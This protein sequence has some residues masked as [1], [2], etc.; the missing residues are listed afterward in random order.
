MLRKITGPEEFPL[1]IPMLQRGLKF[2]RDERRK[3]TH[4]LYAHEMEV[5]RLRAE[6]SISETVENVVDSLVRTVEEKVF[7]EESK[8]IREAA[9]EETKIIKEVKSTMIS[10]LGKVERRISKEEKEVSKKKVYFQLDSLAEEHVKETC[11]IHAFFHQTSGDYIIPENYHKFS[12]YLQRHTLKKLIA[13]LGQEVR[14]W[15]IMKF[16]N[17]H[18][19]RVR[20]VLVSPDMKAF[21]LQKRWCDTLGEYFMHRTNLTTT[22]PTH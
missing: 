10:L 8:K 4:E 17:V 19:T 9:K 12:A 5:K 16:E 14:N 3:I 18:K 1:A 6:L 7:V 21:T 11:K 22:K 2:W 15:Y 20:Y 13:I